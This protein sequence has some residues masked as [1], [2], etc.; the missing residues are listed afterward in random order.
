M[1]KV[2]S[3]V[4]FG[5]LLAACTAPSTATQAPPSATNTSA[6]VLPTTAPTAVPVKLGGKVVVMYAPEELSEDMQKAFMADNSDIQIELVQND[7]TRFFAMSAAGNAPDLFRSIAP[8]VPEFL[9]RGLLNDLTPYFL[10]STILKEAD[11][12]SANN[13]YRGNGPLEIGSGKIWGMAKDWSPEF[14]LFANIAHFEE[15]GLPVPDDKKPLTY[16]EIMDIGKKLTKTE[17]ERTLRWGYGHGQVQPVWINALAE[18]NAS[19]FSADYKSFSLTDHADAKELLQYFYDIAAQNL[20]ASPVNPSPNG[21]V[22]GDFPAGVVSLAQMGFWFNMMAEGENYKGKV[23]AL[24]APTW[25]GVRRDPGAYLTGMMM[26]SKT[27]VPDAAWRI[28]EWFMGGQPA[29][30]RASSGWGVPSLNSLMPLI[31]EASDFQ[32]QAKAV[33]IDELKYAG[34]PV[35]WNPYI[36]NGGQALEDSW[37]KNLKSALEKEITFDQLLQNMEQDVNQ[38]IQDGIDQIGQ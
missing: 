18:K 25:A 35:R 30:D 28:F 17:G 31:P 37:G 24:P 20:V 33:L 36:V 15:A 3:S 21:W 7:L 14:M 1:L 16:V 11:L 32:K 34:D 6:P 38:A 27:Q 9:A 10:A 12:A 8:W 19:L 5:S 4:A 26:S 22:G 13:A 23:K 2:S 29:K